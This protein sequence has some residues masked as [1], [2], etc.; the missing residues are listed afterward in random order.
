[1]KSTNIQEEYISSNFG[2]E[3]KVMQETSIKPWR[4]RQYIISG[5]LLNYMALQAR[6]LYSYGKIVVLCILII[7]FSDGQWTYNVFKKF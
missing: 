1:M 4:W 5:L 6:R 3:E 2:I 7:M